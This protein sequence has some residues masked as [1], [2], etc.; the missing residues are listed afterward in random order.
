MGYGCT[1][2]LPA[3]VVQLY[4]SSYIV[5]QKSELQQSRRLNRVSDW[6]S[7][8]KCRA[9]AGTFKLKSSQL[10][11]STLSAPCRG[12]PLPNRQPWD[13]LRN[14]LAD[15]SASIRATARGWWR[16]ACLLGPWSSRC[17]HGDINSFQQKESGFY[18]MLQQWL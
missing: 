3:V 5:V 7:D 13:A 15:R 4:S 14:G 8:P 16:R 1:H 10:L 12:V 9:L 17:A 11:W 18:P 2:K 6:P